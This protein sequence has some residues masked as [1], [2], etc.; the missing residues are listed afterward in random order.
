VTLRP[1]YNDAEIMFGGQRLKLV[2]DFRTIDLI[3]GLVGEPMPAI[4]PRV[5][6]MSPSYGVTTKFVWAMLRHHHDELTLDE[7]AGILLNPEDTALATANG[8]IV[9]DLIKRA[10][11]IE[12]APTP[13][14]K[15]KN[16]RARR[17]ASTTS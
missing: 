5:L 1:F 8:V 13:K 3:E 10:F 14:A 4:L 17:G 6:S 9:E 2:I 7:V 16:P 15:A 12:D 11:H